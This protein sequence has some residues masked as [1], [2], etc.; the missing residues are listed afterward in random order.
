MN[1]TIYEIYLL[2]P[3]YSKTLRRVILSSGSKDLY[4][5]RQNKFLQNWSIID[6]CLL[7]EI[8]IKTGVNKNLAPLTCSSKFV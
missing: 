7:A 4:I 8:A 2:R 1:N 5:H 3:K 6:N